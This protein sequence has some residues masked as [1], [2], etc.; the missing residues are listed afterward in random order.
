MT[1]LTGAISFREV[2]KLEEIETVATLAEEIWNAHYVPI[3]GQYQ[4]KYMLATFQSTVAISRQIDEG[5]IYFIVNKQSRSVGYFALKKVDNPRKCQISKLYVKQTIQKQGVGSA[6]IKFIE[7]YCFK[8]GVDELWL[9]VNK[10][11]QQAINFYQ[12]L[13]FIKTRYWVQDIGN[14]FVMDDCVMN[15]FFLKKRREK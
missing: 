13:G 11:N 8:L 2:T 14:G 15:K 1:H 4:V 5:F 6:S 7:N 10:N 9:T 12:K 3:I